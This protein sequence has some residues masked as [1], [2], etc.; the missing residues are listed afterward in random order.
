[1]SILGT[2]KNCANSRHHEQ[3]G[4]AGMFC[5]AVPPQFVLLPHRGGSQMIGAWAPVDELGWC[6]QHIAAEPLVRQ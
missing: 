1:M 5:H 6:A 3:M 4:G 2:C